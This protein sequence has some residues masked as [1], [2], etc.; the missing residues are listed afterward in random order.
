M[1]NTFTASRFQVLANT[2]LALL[3]GNASTLEHHHI[4]VTKKIF[5]NRKTNI[6][7]FVTSESF[8]EMWK[9]SFFNQTVA[10]RFIRS[11]VNYSYLSCISLIENPDADFGNRYCQTRR[12]TANVPDTLKELHL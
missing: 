4:A 12:S 2:D 9:V 7:Q 11:N 8:S 3:Y 1:I 5:D 6:F 10:V